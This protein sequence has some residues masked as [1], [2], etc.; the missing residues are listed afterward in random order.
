MR[1]VHHTKIHPLL[2]FLS[3]V[4]HQKETDGPEVK[5]VSVRRFATFDLFIRK[6]LGEHSTTSDDQWVEYK[7]VYFP[8]YSAFLRYMLQKSFSHIVQICHITKS[9]KILTENI[10]S[11]LLFLESNF[12]ILPC[13]IQML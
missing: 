3:Q 8:E 2:L 1:F 7:S 11:L 5:E 9:L 13:L 10:F 4:L 6:T 12:Q